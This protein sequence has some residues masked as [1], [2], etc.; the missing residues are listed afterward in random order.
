MYFDPIRATRLDFS[1]SCLQNS[2]F[3][4]SSWLIRQITKENSNFYLP[5]TRASH[6]RTKLLN[7]FHII[8]NSYI[9][10]LNICSCLSS[11]CTYFKLSFYPNCLLGSATIWQL[12]EA[13]VSRQ[14]HKALLI[15]LWM[16]LDY[17]SALREHRKA[18]SLLFV[19]S[20]Y[21]AT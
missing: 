6:R 15:I 10:K 18:P 7:M 2:N 13:Y 21:R 11:P 5:S 9:S 12:L 17:A 14:N 3:I 19:S 8:V 16:S 4:Y 1:I 20:R